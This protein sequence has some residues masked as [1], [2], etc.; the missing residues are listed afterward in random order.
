MKRYLSLAAILFFSMSATSQDVTM[1]RKK[2]LNLENGTAIK[3][4]DPVAYFLQNKPVKGKK[5]LAVS[6]LGI[7]YYF[8]SEANKEAFKK[9][10][11]RYEPEYGGWCAYAMGNTGEKVTIDPETFKIVDGKLYLFYN[12]YFTNTL[13][14]WNKN[15]AVL[16]KHADMNWPKLLK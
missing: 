3:G 13:K 9:S 10:P 2:H 15:E 14:D 12:R 11:A 5:E 6:Y 1:L 7:L 4:Y 8:A 16:K